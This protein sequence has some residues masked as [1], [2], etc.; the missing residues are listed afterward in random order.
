MTLSSSAIAFSSRS[1]ALSISFIRKGLGEV[2]LEELAGPVGGGDAALYQ[3]VGENL[4]DAQLGGEG[5][6]QSGV[7]LFFNYPFFFD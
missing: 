3:E 6:D 2:G 4:V 1:T 7:A 5:A